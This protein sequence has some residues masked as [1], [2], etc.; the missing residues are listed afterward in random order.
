MKTDENGLRRVDTDIYAD[1]DSVKNGMPGWGIALIVIIVLAAA[2][3]IGYG[4]YAGK[5]KKKN[6]TDAKSDDKAKK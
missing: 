1:E 4:I 6:K 5:K 3:G 2:G